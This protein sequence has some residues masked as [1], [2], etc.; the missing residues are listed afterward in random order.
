VKKI[1]TSEK[2]F[3]MNSIEDLIERIQKDPGLYTIKLGVLF[4]FQILE[5]MKDVALFTSLINHLT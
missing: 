4:S 3:K 1:K 2:S 5:K